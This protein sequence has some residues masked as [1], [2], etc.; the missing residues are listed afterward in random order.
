MKEI[1]LKQRTK[2]R[3]MKKE[4]VKTEVWYIT[5]LSVFPYSLINIT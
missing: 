2:E 3:K 5:L 1:E 4:E